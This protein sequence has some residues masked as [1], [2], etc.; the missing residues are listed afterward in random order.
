MLFISLAHEVSEDGLYTVT[1]AVL[2]DRLSLGVIHMFD[3]PNKCELEQ[4]PCDH[5]VEV[6]ME[7]PLHMH[8]LFGCAFYDQ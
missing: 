6:F 4:R 5:E 1:L 8:Y 7:R 3:T 2:Q